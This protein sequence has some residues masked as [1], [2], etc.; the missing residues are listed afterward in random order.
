MLLNPVVGNLHNLDTDRYHPILFRE[1][2]LAGGVTG[3]RYLSVGHHTEG[4]DE[5]EDALTFCEEMADRQQ[6]RLCVDKDFL[7]DGEDTPALVVG[8][9]EID[10]TLRPV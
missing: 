1:K 8:F 10:G 3:G 4:F 9:V 7:W 5:R 6:A 2:P